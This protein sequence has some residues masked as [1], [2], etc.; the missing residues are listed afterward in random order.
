ME[1]LKLY[2]GGEWVD[3]ASGTLIEVENPATKEI[4]AKV[5]EGNEE[6]VNR[7]VNAAKEGFK[8]WKE[9]TAEQRADR[10]DKVAEYLENNAEKICE[11]ITKEL[12][13]PKKIVK[14]W[15]VDGAIAEAR[16]FAQVARDF[17][18]EVKK[19]GVVIR[20]EPV[21][22]VAGLTPWNF[23]L[24]QITVKLFPALAAG[25]A[26]ILKPSQQTPL[27]AYFV[28]EATKYAGFPAGV[29]NVV[30]GRGGQVGNVLARHPDIQM[31]SFTGSTSAGKEVG[32]LGLNNVKKTALELGGKSASVILESASV[33][34]AVEDTLEKCF[35][36]S[37]QICSGLTRM[38]APKKK[39]DAIEFLL[40][41]KAVGYVTG[42]PE[43]ESV[44]IGPVINEAAFQKIKKYIE[45]G[46]E[47]GAQMLV[48]EVPEGYDEGYFIKPVIFTDVTND[49]TIAQEEIFGPVLSV[50]YYETE[51]EALRIA[52]DSPYGLS[53]A[54][55]GEAAKARSFAEKMETGVVHIN[56]A[57]FTVEAPFGGYKQSG[58]GRENSV[59]SFDEYLEIKAMLIAE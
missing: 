24:D 3:G 52:N 37:G 35:I 1:Q 48:G 17:E 26:V 7:A 47:E 4:F 25:N 38:I 13:A 21:G 5:P 51:A 53:G 34:Y 49:M 27:S 16:F 59:Y 44:D 12:G 45:I 46:L 14:A 6:D 43:D 33:E 18:Y 19:P 42:N 2:I 15:H 23:P 58:L 41:E 55:F 22:I 36:N 50:I 28:V 57:P 29:F 56:G 11:V 20:R 54:V 32:R 30:T 31:V 40:K 39:K 10:L 8:V 9:F